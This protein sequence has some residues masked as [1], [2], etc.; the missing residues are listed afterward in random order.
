MA[1]KPF[2]AIF[3]A[4]LDNNI[5][6][7]QTFGN[8]ITPFTN[9]DSHAMIEF[10]KCF[11]S[12]KICHDFTTN[13]LYALLVVSP[14]LTLTSAMTA[15]IRDSQVISNS[16]DQTAYSH[17][18]SSTSSFPLS[19]FLWKIGIWLIKQNQR[20]RL[21]ICTYLEF[22]LLDVWRLSYQSTYLA[23]DNLTQ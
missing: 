10:A 22:M 7:T 6:P 23:W 17:L 9:H 2:L 18:S 5:K 11:S 19:R 8:N 1:T 16:L 4:F 14:S 20:V 13:G 12:K 15:R 3:S 21:L